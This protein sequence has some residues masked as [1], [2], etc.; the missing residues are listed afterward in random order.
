MKKQLLIF[1]F[2]I[3]IAFGV[4]AQTSVGAGLA[5]GSEIESAGIGFNALFNAS[6]VIDIS[7][8]FIYYFPNNNV[9]WWELNGNVNYIF[10]EGDATFYGIAG[11]NITG[12]K[13]DLGPFGHQSDSELGLNLGVGGNFDIG[14]NLTPFAEAKYVVGNADQL[15][16][17]AGVRFPLN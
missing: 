1:T 13:V 3:G 15:S 16:L 4:S 8:S 5:F 10:S 11:L 2:F 14:S 6:D 17:F 7:P 9:T 12:V